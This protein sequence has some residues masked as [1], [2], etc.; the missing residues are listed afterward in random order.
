MRTR[1]L[2]HPPGRRASARPGVLQA[3]WGVASGPGTSRQ[4]KGLSGVTQASPAC[5]C[6]SRRPEG[7]M[8]C[9][10]R[11]GSRLSSHFTCQNIPLSIPFR[12]PCAKRHPPEHSV[13]SKGC[14]SGQDA[15]LPRSAPRNQPPL[16]GPPT[17][18]ANH[19]NTRSLG[20]LRPPS[21]LPWPALL[22]RPHSS[23]SDLCKGLFDTET[24]KVPAPEPFRIGNQNSCSKPEFSRLSAS[25]VLSIS[26]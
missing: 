4:E 26:H 12:R 22:K 8:A 1:C 16:L 5:R 21:D 14:R 6:E 10:R 18:A 9:P 7:E 2:K 3:P 20:L 25:M 24:S 15:L 19:F 17:G 23:G 13:L 11:P